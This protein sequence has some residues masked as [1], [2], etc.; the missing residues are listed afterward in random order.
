[1][2]HKIILGV[3][4]VLGIVLHIMLEMFKIVYSATFGFLL[5]LLLLL[6]HK[7]KSK[8][9]FNN[10]EYMREIEIADILI[11]EISLMSFEK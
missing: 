9:Y 4:I 5:L 10:I 8:D 1:M 2:T 7:N 11:G 6:L 3:Q